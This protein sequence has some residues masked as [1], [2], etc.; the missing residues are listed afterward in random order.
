MTGLPISSRGTT[1]PLGAPETYNV[2]VPQAAT[3][4]A[5]PTAINNDQACRPH[6]LCKLDMNLPLGMCQNRSPTWHN[7]SNILLK[8]FQLGPEQD[9]EVRLAAGNRSLIG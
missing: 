7:Y 5:N 3:P 2:D 9:K 4:I 1:L 6:L 8:F